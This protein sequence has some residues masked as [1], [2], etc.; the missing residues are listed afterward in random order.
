MIQRRGRAGSVM[1]AVRYKQ[2]EFQRAPRIRYK[3]PEGKLD[4]PPPAP[5]PSEPSTSLLVIGLPAG[6]MLIMMAALV[7]FGLSGKG[8][9]FVLVSV[10]L[11]LSSAMVSFITHF[12]QK[13]KYKLTTEK[14]A[15]RYE[16]VLEKYEKLLNQAYERQQ[17]ALH[18]TY[19]SFMG[20]YERVKKIDRRL[21]ERSYTD[22]DFLSLRVGI[23]EAPLT[24]ELKVPEQEV[25]IFPDPLIT[26]AQEMVDKY[27]VVRNIPITVDLRE[28][29]IVGLAGERELTLNTMRVLVSQVAAHH[30]PD[31]VKVV[32]VFPRQERMEWGWARWLPHTWSDDRSYRFLADDRKASH[33]LL[34]RLHETLLR[35]QLQRDTPYGGKRPTSPPFFVVFLSDPS[36]VEN[37]PVIRTLLTTGPDLGAYTVFLG[38]SIEALPKECRV[39]VDLQKG[40]G[41]IRFTDA[42]DRV[43]PFVPDIVNAEPAERFSRAMAPIRLKSV[44]SVA[45]IPKTVTLL[46]LW[47]TREIDDLDSRRLWYENRPFKSLAVPLGFMSGGKPLLFDIHEKAHGPHGLVAGATGSGKSE[48]L[49]SMICSMAV[50]FHPHEVAFILVDYKGGGMA[51]HFLD[52]PHLIG[53]M[54]N[55][56]GNLTNR[57][58]TAIKSEL[59]R[60]QEE[61]AKAGV[62]HIDE[63]QRLYRKGKTDKPLPHLVII[64]DEFAE[65]ASEKPEFMRELVSAVRVGRSLGVHLILATQKPAGVVS[66]QIWGN[67]RFR[68]CLRVERPEDSREVL[69]RPDA[70]DITLPGRA[71]LQVGNDELFELFQSAWSGAPYT[72]VS[73]A[74]EEK[75]IFEVALDGTRITR[76]G[77]KGVRTEHRATTQL[78][79]VV[80]YLAKLAKEEGIER[81]QGPWLDP[82]PETLYFEDIAKEL[83]YAGGPHAWEEPIRSLTPFIGLVDD[84]ANQRQAPLFLDLGREGHLA[85]YGLPGCGKTTLLQTLIRSLSCLY[86]PSDLNIYI[87]DFGGRTLSLFRGLPH[88]GDIVNEEEDEKV[89]GLLKFLT[90]ELEKRKSLFS[91]LGVNTLW[92][93]RTATREAKPD[94]VVCIDNYINFV[95]LYGDELEDSLARLVQEGGNVGIH[96][97][98]TATAHGQIRTKL[99]SNISLTVAMALAE[100]GDYALIVG[101]TEGLYPADVPGRGLI[102]GTPPLEFQTALPAYGDTES[103][104]ANTILEYVK[105]LADAYKGPRAPAIPTVPEVIS[106]QEIFS[107]LPEEVGSYMKRVPLGLTVD[108]FEPFV[109][110]LDEGPYFLIAGAAQSGKSTLLKSLLVSLC[111]LHKPSALRLYIV[112]FANKGLRP[113]KDLPHTE[114]FISTYDALDEAIA[115]ITE[116]LRVRRE[117]V[118]VEENDISMESTVQEYTRKPL[119]FMAIEDF[120][121]FGDMAS[122]QS[123]DELERIIRRERG[124]GFFLAMVGTTSD[125]SSCWDGYVKALMEAQTGFLLGSTGHEDLNIFKLRL[126]SSE[127]NQVLPPGLGYFIKRGRARKIKV[128]ISGSEGGSLTEFIPSL[129]YRI[130][131]RE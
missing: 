131:E 113:F 93:Y 76:G 118:N 14:R 95:S 37:E 99:S 83:G 46:D 54:T 98:I 28:A 88:V 17:E 102:K 38:D 75:Q 69:K 116:E 114:R 110:D 63:Y 42:A 29:G 35:R 48:L 52:L 125:L 105:A 11:M 78:R 65:L 71:Y 39:I 82:L 120:Y 62:N 101:R 84:P 3:L 121:L 22:D 66:E 126:P 16:E 15:A 96:F 9:W 51:N 92:A 5:A 70:A 73:I 21:W 12:Q 119:L 115:E 10:P 104:R 87:M 41:Y 53:V 32:A 91:E 64:I 58:L 80:D 20:C 94:I 19:P 130:G 107:A 128:A 55:L 127:S 45:D 59:R 33:A 18:E 36:L 79:A 112:D 34:T 68:I 77:E 90:R 72:G 85:V 30:S 67:S 4:I 108:D 43:L 13:K 97:V 86:S 129:S 49:Q 100:P 26:R 47:N 123:K 124:T 25:A 27:R 106:L 81:L 89:R 50:N 117:A 61:L 23:G 24:L 57:A 109:L 7:Y 111:A 122:S 1:E 40:S 44:V 74:G 2:L 60:R 8:S 56:E 31:E 103:D 6:G